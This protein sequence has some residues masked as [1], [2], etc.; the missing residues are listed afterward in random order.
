MYPCKLENST[1]SAD[2]FKSLKAKRFVHVKKLPRRL[3]S[4]VQWERDA[5]G[6]PVGAP[7]G[8][9]EVA[10]GSG[11]SSGGACR[12]LPGIRRLEGSD[13]LVLPLVGGG[14]GSTGAL[15]RVRQGGG[16]G[17]R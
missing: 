9:H 17:G 5:A 8:L 3:E 13:L 16:I 10:S 15:H 14:P 6:S 11:R 2:G 12:K 1:V 4:E 7:R